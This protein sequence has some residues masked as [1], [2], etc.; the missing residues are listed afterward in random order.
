MSWTLMTVHFVM[1]TGQYNNKE[2]EVGSDTGRELFRLLVGKR[3]IMRGLGLN[4]M[5]KSHT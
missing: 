3:S 4:E 5:S 1:A 2:L